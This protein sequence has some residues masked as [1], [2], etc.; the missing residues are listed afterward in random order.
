MLPRNIADD[1]LLN[2]LC[3]EPRPNLVQ[4]QIAYRTLQALGWI[5]YNSK[6]QVE[7]ARACWFVTVIDKKEY[8]IK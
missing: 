8:G 1:I 7:I 3:I 6:T 2:I 4:R 5:A